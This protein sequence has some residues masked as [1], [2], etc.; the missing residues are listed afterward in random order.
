MLIRVARPWEMKEA[1]A[2]PERVFRERRRL[3]RELGLGLGAAIALVAPG[4]PAFA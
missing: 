3:L 4:P 2:T 1:A